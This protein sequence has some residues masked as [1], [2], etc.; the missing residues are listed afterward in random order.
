LS[1]SSVAHSDLRLPNRTSKSLQQLPAAWEGSELSNHFEVGVV[2]GLVRKHFGIF[3]KEFLSALDF[4]GST[5][6]RERGGGKVVNAVQRFTAF[7]VRANGAE[8]E[9][10]GKGRVRPG[11]VVDADVEN[12]YTEIVFCNTELYWHIRIANIDISSP[13]GCNL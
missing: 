2:S 3:G 13:L 10:R 8:R 7:P 9:A 1:P 11:F 4:R 5:W 12:Q 6:W